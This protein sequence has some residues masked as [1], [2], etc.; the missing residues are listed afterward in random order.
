MSSELN[1]QGCEM[2]VRACVMKDG[3][4]LKKTE[5]ISMVNGVG[6]LMWNKVRIFVAG[7]AIM[8]N[9]DAGCHAA[10]LNLMTQYSQSEKENVLRQIGKY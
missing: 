9:Y 2:F 6:R 5:Q 7:R 1:L 8:D 3:R 10:Y 4:R